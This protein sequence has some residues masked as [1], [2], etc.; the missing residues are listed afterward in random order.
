MFL[1]RASLGNP[2]AVIV[3]ALLLTLFGLISLT[4]LPIQLTPE[5]EEPQITITTPWRGAAPNEVEADILE[6]QE[7]VLRGLPGMV[8]MLSQAG[9]GSGEIVITFSVDMDMRRAL[10][11]IINR[12]NQ[13]PSYPEDVD[14]PKIST[15]GANA[16]AIAWF[17]IRTAEGNDRNIREYKD[18]IEETVRARFERVPGVARSEV[19]GGSDNELRI[20]FDPYKAAALGLQLPIIST[21]AGSAKDTSAGFQP[22]DKRDYSLRFAGRYSARDLG[23]MIIEWRAGQ[24]VYLR[25]VAVI[26]RTQADADGFVLTDFGPSIAVNAQRETGVNVLQVMA[27]LRAAVQELNAGPI[28]RAGLILQQVHDET[29][30]IN[31]S[32]RMLR[33]NLGLG[34]ALA[35]LVLFCFFLRFRAT[36]IIAVSIPLCLLGG[37]CFMYLTGRTLNVISLAGL[38]LAMGMVLDASIV[39]LENITRLREQARTARDACHDGARE[40]WGALFAST[41]TTVAVFLPIIYL[42]DEA[43]QLFSDLAQAITAAILVSLV[44]AVTVVPAAAQSWLGKVQVVDRHSRFWDVGSRLVMRLTD[45]VWRRCFWITVLVGSALGLAFMFLPK[46]DYLPDGNQNLVFAIILPPPGASVDLVEQE[47]GKRIA[48]GIAPYLRG[49]KQP[50]V[51]R[52]FFV[53]RR[54][55]VFMGAIAKD[56]RQVGQLVPVLNRLLGQL[57][58]SIAFA[59]QISLFGRFAAGRTIELH[60]QGRDLEALME[61][62]S[63]V[64]IQLPDKLPGAAVRPLPGLELAQPELRMIPDE[65][66]I[67]EA[68]WH[69]GTLA[70]IT[71]ALGDGVQVGDYFD[72]DKNIDIVLRARA[73]DSPEELAAMP[74]V[75]PN[76]GTLPLGELLQ[77]TRTAGPEEIR[78]IN[79]RRTVTLEVSPPVTVALEDALQLLKTEIEPWVAERLP[80]D[81]EVSY[82]GSA[83]KLEQAIGSMSGSF[84]LA[85]VIL[86]LLMS[87]LFRSFAASLLVLMTVPLAAVG[88]V[89]AL[90]LLNVFTIQ[91]MDLLTMIGFIISLGLVVNN[92]ILLVD[93]T[94]TAERAGQGRRQAVAGAV[95]QRLR[96]IVISTLTTLSG[97]LPLM[98]MPG[99]GTELYRGL[100]TVIVGGLLV[101][102]LFTLLLLPSL[103]RMGEGREL[104]GPQHV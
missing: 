21:L 14:E 91:N 97:M 43:G 99:A 33:N 15:V 18:Y 11:E 83:G 73:W 84:L 25:D 55:S 90:R 59:R 63:Q 28:P 65:R 100:A 5:I 38:A 37:F 62:A 47:M 45:T 49:E 71:R 32:I 17:I 93:K 20:T 40:V 96:P 102:A 7:D 35:V 8:E 3:G 72:G 82:G 19:F 42:R 104:R 64:F 22:L 46:A 58:D 57:P 30:Y 75:T 76:S 26:E 60:I 34:I 41:V 61:I 27:G 56:P 52:Y 87:A 6:P 81:G 50:A 80:E 24:P 29:V 68:G 103:L 67:T 86:Y 98:L 89:L 66:R 51:H 101:S 69:R 79:R 31:Q 85:I 1:T 9:R 16:R 74:L 12:L 78:R 48:A 10:I 4:R 23:A 88:G 77:L 13:V 39:V 94:R 70:L 95:R 44:C 53:G 2:V 92:A 54:G 36:L